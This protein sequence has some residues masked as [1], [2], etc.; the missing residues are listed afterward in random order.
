MPNLLEGNIGNIL[1]DI[2]IME[3]F[4]STVNK[5]EIIKISG[6]WMELKNITCE[7][8]QIYKDKCCMIFAT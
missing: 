2:S 6:T 7:V 3:N 8:T 5:N 1:H 4:Y